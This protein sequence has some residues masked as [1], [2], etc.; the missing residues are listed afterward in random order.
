MT[1]K[2]RSITVSQSSLETTLAIPFGSVNSQVLAVASRVRGLRVVS[3]GRP[4]RGMR[5]L[6]G[7]ATGIRTLPTF[8]PLNNFDDLTNRVNICR[9]S[10]ER[11]SLRGM[12]KRR[13]FLKKRTTWLQSSGR[14]LFCL[15]SC[16]LYNLF[17]V[18]ETLSCNRSGFDKFERLAVLLV[19]LIA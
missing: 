16:H 4:K 18:S 19:D 7:T 5:R 10:A 2:L 17:A 6:R 14:N 13:I 1:E 12:K 8:R 11:L 3:W 9:Y 15:L